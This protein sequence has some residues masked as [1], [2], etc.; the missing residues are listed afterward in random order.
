MKDK[1]FGVVEGF[2]RKPYTLEQRK[3]LI[4]YLSR[5]G[6]NT[7]IYGPKADVYHRKKWSEPYPNQKMKEFQI[8]SELA[9]K[10][11]VIF[12]YALSPMATPDIKMIIRK[13]SMMMEI[14]IQSFS[15]FFDDIRVPITKET[16]IVQAQVANDLFQFLCAKL[17]KPVLFF[18]PTQYRGFDKTDYLS[19]ITH[20]LIKDIEIFWTGKRVVSPKITAR[21]IDRYLEITRRPPLIWDN[22]FANDYIP[23]VVLKF[24]YRNRE[25]SIIEKVRGIVINP[26][27]QYVASKPLIYTAA[28]FFRYPHEYNP[29]KAWQEATSGKF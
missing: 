15:L 21:D 1:F 2:Y 18:C 14:G 8:L 28:K 5:L 27:N 13:T 3:D 26:M 25:P 9:G 16:A 23:G 6:L 4:K 12:N 11:S 17:S 20:M 10:Y 29:K 24:P 19:I 22:L 7:Y